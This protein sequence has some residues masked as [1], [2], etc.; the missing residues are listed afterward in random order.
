MEYGITIFVLGFPGAIWSE[1]ATD[2]FEE[3][4]YA[5]KWRILMAKIVSYKQSHDES[6]PYVELIDTNKDTVSQK[7]LEFDTMVVHDWHRQGRPWS[8]RSRFFQTQYACRSWIKSRPRSTWRC[9]SC[10]TYESDYSNAIFRNRKAVL[11]YAMLHNR[12]AV[13]NYA[14]LYNKEAVLNYAML[15]NVM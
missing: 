1:E 8:T 3:L 10:T 4:T 5:A 6:I 11:D 14:I 7:D 12:E 13:V 9:Q 15:R 2:L